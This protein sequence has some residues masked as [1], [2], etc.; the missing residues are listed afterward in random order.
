MT[1]KGFWQFQLADDQVENND[2][3]ADPIQPESSEE[4]EDESDEET[5]QPESNEEDADESNEE[6]LEAPRRSMRETSKPSAYEPSF[7]GKSYAPLFYNTA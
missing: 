6:P 4:D 1:L 2:E 3:E 7:P 5:F